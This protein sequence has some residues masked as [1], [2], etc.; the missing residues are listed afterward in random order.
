MEEYTNREIGLL[1]EKMKE[2]IKH[3]HGDIKDSID[4][5][6]LTIKKHNGRLSKVEVWINRSIGALV[7]VS[8][9]ISGIVFPTVVKIITNSKDSDQKVKEQVSQIIEDMELIPK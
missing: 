7:I 5:L 3:Q 8:I 9:I 2:D 4:G 6:D 1:M